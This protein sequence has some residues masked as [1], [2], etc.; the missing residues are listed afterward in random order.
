MPIVGLLL[1]LAV[2]AGV[3]TAE[4]GGHRWVPLVAACTY[5]AVS[6]AGLVNGLGRATAAAMV[7]VVVG[8]SGALLVRYLRA[9][10][11]PAR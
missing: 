7:G 8:Y 10:H 11:D 9:R 4:A 1:G 6:V 3:R 5:L 2:G